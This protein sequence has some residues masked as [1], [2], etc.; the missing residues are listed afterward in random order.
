M[1][2]ENPQMHNSE[3]SKMLGFE[4]KKLTKEEKQPYIDE[5]NKLRNDH[6]KE[7]PDYKV[8][9]RRKQKS[10]TNK[11]KDPFKVHTNPGIGFPPSFAHP[12]FQYALT[13]DTLAA[14]AQAQ[15]QDKARFMFLSSHYPLDTAPD[16]TQAHLAP[17]LC[18]RCSSSFSCS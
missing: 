5:A 7:Y 10:M 9:P 11:D 17:C 1:A 16:M 8:R 12:G 6:K 3:I 15:A 18:I 2:Q 14:K 4:W 13:A